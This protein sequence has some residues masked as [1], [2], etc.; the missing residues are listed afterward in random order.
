MLGGRD[1]WGWYEAAGALW[2]VLAA[3]AVVLTLYLLGVI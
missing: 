1:P 3:A 2:G